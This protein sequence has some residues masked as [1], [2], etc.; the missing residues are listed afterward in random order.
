MSGFEIVIFS[1]VGIAYVC[2]IAK[3]YRD[4]KQNRRIG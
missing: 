2:V 4:Y 1:L 3:S